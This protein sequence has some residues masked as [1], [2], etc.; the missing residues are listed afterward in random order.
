LLIPSVPTT[1]GLGALTRM[2]LKSVKSNNGK[3]LTAP[4]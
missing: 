1:T 4:S 2:L 3:P